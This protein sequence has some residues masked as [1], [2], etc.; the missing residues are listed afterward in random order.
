MG[1]LLVIECKNGWIDKDTLGPCRLTSE[2]D[3]VWMIGKNAM[4]KKPYDGNPHT[5]HWLVQF[6][7]TLGCRGLQHAI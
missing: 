5:R 7:K 3:G 2:R 4:G 1:L 6:G